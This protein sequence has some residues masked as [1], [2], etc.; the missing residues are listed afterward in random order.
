MVLEVMVEDENSAAPAADK[1][2]EWADTYG[3]TMPVLAAEDAIMYKYAEGMS[4]V[5]LPFTV[6]LDPGNEIY[7]IA[8]GTQVDTAVGR[9]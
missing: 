2:A 6:V 9:L 5:G 7:S 8:S 4:S 3:L 1:A